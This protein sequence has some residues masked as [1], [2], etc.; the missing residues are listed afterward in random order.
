MLMKSKLFT[1]IFIC[2]AVMSQ[3]L[4]AQPL[5]WQESSPSDWTPTTITADLD[6]KTEGS[7]SI[8]ITFT[9]TGTPYF[10]SD[11]FNVTP[12]TAFN[13]SMDILD[14]DAASECNLR[15]RFIAADGSGKNETS[16]EY[17]TDNTAFQ[18]YTLTGTS[19]AT[20]VKAYLVIRMYDVSG[21]WDGTGT[22]NLDNA[23]FTE[24][25]AN[26]IQNAGFED[27][28]VPEEGS[29][30]DNWT[31]SVPSDWVPSIIEADAVNKSHGFF[32]TKITFTETGTP[33]YVSDTFNVTASTAFEYSIDIFENDPGAECNL[34]V[35][36]IADDGSGENATSSEY[37]TDNAAFQTMTFSGTSPATAV[38]AYVIIRMYDVSAGWNESGTFNIDNASYTEGGANL[39]KNPSFE[40]WTPP[41]DAPKF[42]TYSFEGLDPIVNATVN[43][44]K[45][46]IDATI[47]YAIDAT[48]LV[49]TFTMNEG[50]TAKIGTTDQVSGTSVNDFSSPVIYT[51]TGDDAEKDWTVT[52]TKEDASTG[53]DITTFR[54][55]GLD[56][57]VSGNIS[58]SEHTVALEVPHGTDVTALIPSITLS[59]NATI[60]PESGTAKDFTSSVTYTVTAQ[61][62][63]TQEWVVTVSKSAEGQTVLFYEDFEDIKVLPTE[64]MIIN[65]DGYTQ[66]AGEEIWQDSAWVVT[67]TTRDEL[68]GTKLAMASSYTSDMPKDGRAD[69]WMILPTITIGD[70]STLSWQAMS[71]TSSGNYPD[72]YMV[73]IAPAI[74]GADPTISYFESDGNIL[75]EVNPESWSASVS[76]PGKGL[77][78]QSINLK[79]KE[80]SN[81]DV[82]I[83][84]VLTT[85]LY[86]NPTTG[87]P[88]SNAGGSNL[89]ID[90]IKVVNDISTSIKD[91]A[92][93]DFGVSIFPNPANGLFKVSMESDMHAIADIEIIDIVGR[94]VYSEQAELNTGKNYIELNASD[95]KKGL[96]LVNTKINNKVNVSKL[97][98]K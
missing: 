52:V 8:N 93:N 54:F 79:E 87:N 28:E 76:N 11:T 31:E 22:F 73:L 46:S 59:K 40:N 3:N 65:N 14:N 63:S 9:E 47:P 68:V 55:E 36:F 86:T 35:R 5:H 85:D 82:W 58:V 97:L 24:G 2:L 91:I 98:V 37:S 80:W 4:K 21:N 13:Y 23:S 71:T 94:V 33:Y 78:N 72:D 67:T 62:E 26:L 29:T 60:S 66:A 20:A 30:A 43:N 44:D 15:V 74:S 27:W 12:S 92:K 6:Q 1:L 69:D 77:T 83:A 45:F 96:Y 81:K 64:W 17:T 32:S 84:F 39:I 42:L 56:P 25:G 57:I 51:L 49:A 7:A 41:S 19:P 50:I 48:T 95:L 90:N 38:K 75:I 61:D 18:T 70:N 34:R 53:K 89:A 10:V 16:S 88:N